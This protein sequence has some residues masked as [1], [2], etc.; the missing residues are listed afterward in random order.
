MVQHFNRIRRNVI[1][2]GLAAGSLFVPLPYAW[3]WAQS[4]GTMKLLKAPKVALV[5]GNSRYRNSP[6]A[7]PANDARAMAQ[8]LNAVGFDVTLKVDGSKTDMAAVV[9]AYVRMV[10]AKKCVG[11]FYY[12]GH[13]IQLAWRNYMLPVDAD[14]AAIGDIQTQ[15]VEVNELLEGLS[16]AA[17]PMNIVILD[18]CRDNPFG[19]LKGVEHKGLSQMDAPNNTIVSYATAPGNVASDGAGANGLYTENLLREIKVPEAKVE[20]VFKRVRLNV[21]LKSKGAQVPWESSSLEDDF[22]F[23]PPAQLKR[24]SEE[25]EQRQFK[26]E[27]ALWER[28]RDS[29]DAAPLEDYLRRFPSGKFTE[30]AQLQLDRVLAVRGEKRVEVASSVGNPFTKGSASADT[31]YRIGDSYSYRMLDLQSR[32]EKSRF[33]ARVA[34]ITDGEVIFSDGTVTDLLGNTVRNR[35]GRRFSPRQQLPLEYAVG[36]RWHSRFT[37]TTRKGDQEG[38]VDVDMRITAREKITVPAGTFDAFRIEGRGTTTFAKETTETLT[39]RWMA[40]DTVR[41]SIAF[42]E[43]LKAGTKLLISERG[44]LVSFTQS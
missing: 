39:I 24:L 31:R 14:L 25:E 44:E 22:Y 19:S 30:L 29:K 40:P 6:L 38:V 16:A 41:R 21:R 34:Q 12:A 7:N 5:L 26:E 8:A 42:E 4:E 33:A 20:D 1:R 32:A 23:L 9:Q 10:A 11:L 2:G 36:R 37:A 27:L 3:V 28:I 18:A 35:D 17:N 13:A 15:G 43:I